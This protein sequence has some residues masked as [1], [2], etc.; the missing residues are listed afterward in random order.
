MGNFMIEW[1]T[2]NESAHLEGIQYIFDQ[3]KG[4]RLLLTGSI[5]GDEPISMAALWYLAEELTTKRPL[6][7]K[8]TIIPC[9][10]VFATTAGTRL[11]P[12]DGADLNRKFPGALNGSMSERLAAILVTLLE[13]HD[14][15]IDVH[16]A[17]WAIPFVLIDHTENLELK[18]KVIRWARASS[19]PIIQEM[20][21]GEVML[22]GLNRSWS[23]WSLSLGKPAITVELSGYRMIESGAAK[24]GAEVIMKLLEAASQIENGEKSNPKLPF[25]FEILS[26]T[27]GFFE[28]FCAPGDSIVVGM[29]IGVIRDFRGRIIETVTARK[30]GFIL[31]LQPVSSVHPGSWLTTLAVLD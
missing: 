30:E 6:C 18:G 31:D 28:T 19:L 27:T 21:I 13:G 10:N 2:I 4:P 3:N 9:A 8:V 17:G 23:S 22:Q 14:L 11:L 16:S 12:Y 29:N 20:S 1:M 25:R 26:N 7:G 5:H 15:L 24:F